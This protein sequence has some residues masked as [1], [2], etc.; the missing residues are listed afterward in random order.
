MGIVGFSSAV[1][2][3]II[4][5]G[6]TLLWTAFL[7][8][9]DGDHPELRH[10]LAFVLAALTLGQHRASVARHRCGGAGRGQR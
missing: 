4:T 6:L 5:R 8:Q 9:I 2:A 7:R 3:L 1:P 10:V